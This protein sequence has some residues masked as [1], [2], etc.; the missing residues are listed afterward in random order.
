MKQLYSLTFQFQL[1]TARHKTTLRPW[2][3]ISWLNFLLAFILSP[4][5]HI[6]QIS[7]FSD[8]FLSV[9][10]D[11]FLLLPHHFLSPHIFADHQLLT[12][13]STSLLLK[14]KSVPNLMQACELTA[15]LP[16]WHCLPPKHLTLPF[17]CIH[18]IIPS[19]LLDDN[20]NKIASHFY[21]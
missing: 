11:S 13:A 3:I 21:S 16:W 18:S 4:F 12:P 8:P 1:L 17:P 14:G 7:L 5:P 19:S 10:R 15:W 20:N 2:L 9:L 6:Q